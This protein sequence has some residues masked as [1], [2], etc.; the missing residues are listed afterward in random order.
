MVN[1]TYAKDCF[2]LGEQLSVL[3]GLTGRGVPVPFSC[4]SGACQTCL[5]RATRGVPPESAQIG[6]KDS[7]KLQNYFLACVCHPTEDLEVA[8]PDD[9]QAALP[10]TVKKL[11][12]LNGDIMQVV[13][14][15]HAPIEYRPGQ[16][17]NLARDTGL[18][19]AY[20]I[21]S[22]PHEDDHIHLHVRRLPNGR[23]SGWIHEQLRV[24][25][26]VEIRG[27]AGD[28]FYV[29]G[30]PEQGLILIG[31]GSGLAPLYGI[32]RDAL[33]HGHSGPIRLFHGSRDRSGLYLVGE[34]NDL[35]KQ[36][37]NFDY[38]PCLSG[39]DVPHQYAKGRAH[40]VALRH[41]PNLKNWRMYLC[42]HPEMVK[43][44]KKNAFLAGASMKDIYA[45]AFNVSLSS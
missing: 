32:I 31:T 5:M 43:S 7:L 41:V 40:E 44:A 24:G 35:V 17:I 8:L 23:V 12:L 10:A 28:C 18:V 38:V 2:P 26:T 36:Y 16:F 42:G 20:S 14:E 34:L 15:S 27:P 9:E 29:P 19:R 45:D 37:S 4:R 22:V 21:A 30:N 6:L 3:D 13:L 25:Q 11:E 39:E 1:I 33:H